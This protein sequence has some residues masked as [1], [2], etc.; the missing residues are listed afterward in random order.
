MSMTLAAFVIRF[1]MRAKT[2][3]EISRGTPA[4]GGRRLDPRSSKNLAHEVPL[5]SQRSVDAPTRTAWVT[6]R[7]HQNQTTKLMSIV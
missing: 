5:M 1:S 3:H 4:S 2:S 7:Q 6:I